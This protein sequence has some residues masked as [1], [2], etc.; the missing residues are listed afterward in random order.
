[1]SPSNDQAGKAEAKLATTAREAGP[2]RRRAMRCSGVV[3]ATITAA[4]VSAA[5]PPRDQRGGDLRRCCASPCR[6]RSAARS[7]PALPSRN[8]RPSAWPVAKIM[9]WFTPRMVA[10]IE[11]ADSAANARGNAGEDAIGNAG[12]APARWLPRRRAR[13]C[14]GR[15]PCSR[16]TRLFSRA[17]SIRRSI[18]Q[19]AAPRAGRRACRRIRARP[20]GSRARARE[21]RQARHEQ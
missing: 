10:G 9:A 18:C 4:G 17:S 14:T 15:R 8:R 11:A 19:P 13:T 12:L 7:A 5:S 1:M 3:A 6:S 16:S 20:V 21:H 2:V